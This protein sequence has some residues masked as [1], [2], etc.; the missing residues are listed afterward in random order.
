[1]AVAWSNEFVYWSLIFILSFSFLKFG[2]WK[3]AN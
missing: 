1:L 3:K 2:K